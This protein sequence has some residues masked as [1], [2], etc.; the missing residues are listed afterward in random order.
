MSSECN[1]A[2]TFFFFFALYE[3]PVF[4]GACSLKSVDLRLYSFLG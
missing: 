3:S 1:L 4:D 2:P